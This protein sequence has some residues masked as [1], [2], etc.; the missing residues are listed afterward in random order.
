MF[1][2]YKRINRDTVHSKLQAGFAQTVTSNVRKTRT[3][4]FQRALRQINNP[5]VFFPAASERSAH[6]VAIYLFCCDQSNRIGEK[7]RTKGEWE[8]IL[9]Y[10]QTL[11]ISLNMRISD[12]EKLASAEWENINITGEWRWSVSVAQR[13]PPCMFMKCLKMPYCGTKHCFEVKECSN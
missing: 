4:F 8:R 13:I 11:L 12:D 3:L 7:R 5:S 10:C 1:L 6:S 9:K 2:K